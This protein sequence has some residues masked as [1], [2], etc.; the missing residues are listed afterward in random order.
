ML[1]ELG[2]SLKPLH[3]TTRFPHPL[4]TDE[5]GYALLDVCHMLK[6]VRNTLADGGILKD[7]QGNKIH[8]QYFVELH[9][10]QTTE[11]LRLRKKFKK[12]HLEWRQQKMKVNLA[13]QV[14]SLVLLMHCSF[15]QKT[16]NY[17]YL[18]GLLQQ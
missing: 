9:K 12:V 16:S 14:L 5:K 15:V 6:P 10:L 18:K 4:N 2:A 13:A 1:P 7:K 17:R 3:L 11:G 8:W